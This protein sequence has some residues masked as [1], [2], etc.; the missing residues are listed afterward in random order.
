MGNASAIQAFPFELPN[1]AI[2]EIII[3][4]ELLTVRA[5]NLAK[6]GNCLQY[7][8]ESNSVHSHYVRCKVDSLIFAPVFVPLTTL[9]DIS[10][11]SRQ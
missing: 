2:D 1:F 10:A 9:Q 5:H 3:S 8:Q 7:Q 4:E 11:G 6:S